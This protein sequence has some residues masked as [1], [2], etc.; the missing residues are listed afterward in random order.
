MEVLIWL[1]LQ[2]LN[3]NL[4]SAFYATKSQSHKEIT[5]NKLLNINNLWSLESRES[6]Y[7]L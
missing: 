4:K 7:L 5:K 2:N 6:D 3:F 1:Y